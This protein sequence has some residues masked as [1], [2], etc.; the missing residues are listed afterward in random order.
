MTLENTVTLSSALLFF[1]FLFV[2]VLSIRILLDNKPPEVS[3]AWLLA[4]YFLPYAGA[5]IY[6]L[7]G[8]N[9]KKKK[10]MKQLPEKTFEKFLGPV[11]TRQME[12]M[13]GEWDNIE[14]DIAKNITLAIKSGNSIITLNNAVEMYSQ[15]HSFF[16]KLME[17]L[18]NA[19]DSIN[20]EFFIFRSDGMG[21]RIQSILSRKVREGVKVKMIFD[22]VGCFNKMSRRFKKELRL[23]GIETRYFLNPMN[24]LS[25]RL[26]NYRNHR[27]I[28]VIDGKT[29]YT[30]GMNI[31]LEYLDGGK[32]Y[33]SWR[34]SMIRVEGEAVQMLQGVFLSDWYNSGGEMV[35]DAG[36]FPEAEQ[37]EA[38]LPMQIVC[39]GPDSEWNSLRMMFA[40]L[41]H[42]ANDEIYIQSPYFV[43]ET[44]IMNALTTAALSGV[45]VHLM[46]T[47]IPDKYIPFWVAHTY[48]EE[49]IKAGVHVYLYEKGFLHSKT[50]V[51][52]GSIATIGSCNIDVRS[53][54]LDYEANAFIYDKTFAAQLI[55]KFHEDSAECRHISE[56]DIREATF[57]GR[58][59]NSI[60]RI[61]A[62]L[63]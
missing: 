3:I 63:L 62:P 17:D 38:Q 34:D 48:F 23:S 60:F 58:L 16:E 31:G 46:M 2:A 41:I 8:V 6:L 43:P 4:I 14:N 55:D 44:T 19:V 32:K 12:F 30:G 42:N 27:K 24:V 51:V 37:R 36:F 33:H 29:G 18:E 22:G 25:G 13:K 35:Y 15:G 26:L 50:L 52:D 49:L 1:Y 45:E 28:V 11:L 5:A 21:R 10:I 20:L 7:S 61:I 47:G 56:S 40:G 53:F 59:R 9:W 39:S 54:N 57:V